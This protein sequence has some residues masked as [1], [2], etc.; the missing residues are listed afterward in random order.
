M[1]NE[2]KTW[3]FRLYRGLLY[4]TTQLYNFGDFFI[5]QYKDPDKNQ[6]VFHGCFDHCSCVMIFLIQ[7][8]D[9]MSL[10][11][12]LKYHHLK[13]HVASFPGGENEGISFDKSP[14][15]DPPRKD[16]RLWHPQLASVGEPFDT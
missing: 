4:T 2:K 14:R 6:P 1:S 10:L 9:S 8:L 12:S 11:A 5:S 7:G 3:L 13:A 15:S 16:E